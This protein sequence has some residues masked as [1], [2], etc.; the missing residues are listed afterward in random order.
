MNQILNR[1]I[2]MLKIVTP[3]VFLLGTAAVPAYSQTV[4]PNT[5]QEGDTAVADDVN[6]NFQSLADAIDQIEL[7]PGPEGSQGS[8]GPEGSPGQ[9]GPPFRSP[10]GVSVT[11][12]SGPCSDLQGNCDTRRTGTVP[13]VHLT[14]CD[15]AV[16]TPLDRPLDPVPDCGAGQ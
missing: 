3:M 10:G 2:S 12:L 9:T 1:N 16:L 11:S 13:G 15:N 4:V 14:V 8:V 7:T 6:E 5:F